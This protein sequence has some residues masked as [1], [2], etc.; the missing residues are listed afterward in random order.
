[1]QRKL[2]Y[3]PGTKENECPLGY[4]VRLAEGNGFRHLGLLLAYAGL[5]WKNSRAPIRKILEGEFDVEEILHCVGIDNYSSIHRSQALWEK[6]RTRNIF[7]KHPKLCP[8][9]V[10]EDGY[11]KYSWSF[12]P[13][14][15]C[16]T[17][18]ILLVDTRVKDGARLS[19]YRG[20][21]L[22]IGEVGFVENSDA[23]VAK[24]TALDISNYFESL[25][26]LNPSTQRVS[27]VLVGLDLHEAWSLIYF[28]A[29]YHLRLKGVRFQPL[30]HTNLEMAEVLS[31]TWTFIRN[32]PDSF[33]QML[34]QYI[35]TPMSKRGSAGV[36][37]HFRDISEQLHRE[38]C[39]KGIQRIK[40]EFDRYIEAYWPGALNAQDYARIDV[41]LDSRSIITKKEAARILTCRPERISKLASSK[42]LTVVIFKGKVHYHRAEV[43]A[44]ASM[45]SNN[46]TMAEAYKRLDISRFQ[47]KQILDANIIATLQVPD[48][49]NRDWIIDRQS[50]EN[51]V[52]DLISMAR[53][54][55]DSNQGLSLDGIQRQGYAI[56]NLLR[57]MLAGRVT[58]SALSHSEKP[59]S[60]KRF[61]RFVVADLLSDQCH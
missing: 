41:S 2:I 20:S 56:P 14:I 49:Y 4:L 17:H 3:R 47:L 12:L 28:I 34:S 31:D 60:L 19:W 27:P 57:A 45:V 58:Y 54:N 33:Y 8:Y 50:C 26:K 6:S 37:K 42:K 22:A 44:Y 46:W 35:D 53:R 16:A 52:A 40:S 23:K 61:D 9:C 30:Q 10:A 32:W 55:V 59:L 25:I 39:N 21:M 7:V 11:C 48:R 5:G 51:L 18:N 43:I 36:N 13:V 29:H 15:A 24:R 1:M 38:G